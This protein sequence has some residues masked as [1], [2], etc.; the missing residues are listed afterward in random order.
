MPPFLLFV[1][2]W[3]EPDTNAS[4]A[5]Q[6]FLLRSWSNP[7]NPS[8]THFSFQN[9]Y[10]S[11][12]ESSSLICRSR[13]PHPLLL[14]APVDPEISFVVVAACRSSHSLFFLF[15][16]SVS[17]ASVVQAAH[18]SFRA[19]LFPLRQRALPPLQL[20]YYC[21]LFVRV[22]FSSGLLF[23]CYR[24]ICFISK[25]PLLSKPVS[26]PLRYTHSLS[27]LPHPL[28]LDFHFLLLASFVGPRLTCFPIWVRVYVGSL[29]LF[30]ASSSLSL[31]S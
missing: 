25:I 4:A 12:D 27:C 7:F 24:C 3:I 30:C 18:T 22:R 8:K 10:G 29:R 15:L 9:L 26:F 28:S 1:T 2:D 14:Y 31:T 21:L 23:T 5:R 13:F 20:L 11:F 16:S 17:Y 6:L 19:F